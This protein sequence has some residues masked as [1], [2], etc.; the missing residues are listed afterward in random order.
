MLSHEDELLMPMPRIR[1]AHARP[2]NLMWESTGTC[3][4]TEVDG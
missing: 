4:G 2:L 3:V 1:V